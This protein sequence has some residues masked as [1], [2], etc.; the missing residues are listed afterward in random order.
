[1]P[2]TMSQAS[3]VVTRNSTSRE[4]PMISKRLRV[5]FACF[6]G[7]IFAFAVQE[8]AVAQGWSNGYGY[9]RA[10][11]IDHT[12]VAN[13]DQT[14][15][16]VLI[17]GTFSYLA[18]IENGGDLTSANGYDIIFTSDAAG[19]TPLSYERASYSSVTGA[20]IFWVKI[21]TL[22]HTSDTVIYMFYG[23]G[24]IS[25]DQS[26]KSGTWD[27]NYV[28]VWHFTNAG[29]TFGA[30]STSHAYNLT[31]N[32]SVTASTGQIGGGASFSGSN[33]L[34]NSSLSIT[35][36]TSITISFWNYVSSSNLTQDSTFTIGG[37]D[38]PNRI[39]AACPWSDSTLYWDYGSYSAGGRVSTSY[40]SYLNHWAHVVLEYDSAQSKHAIYINGV[41][42][43]SN[44]NSN[45]P[46]ATETGIDIGA[47]P[48]SY[49]HKGGLDEFRVSTNARSSDWIA[50]EFANQNA[51]S[52]FYAIGSADTTGSGG[53]SSPTISSLSP[54]SGPV[55]IPVSI[56]GTNFGASQG[57]N[58]VTFNGTTAYPTSWTASGI[59]V[60]VPSGATNGNVVVNVAGV[61]SNGANFTVTTGPGITEIYPRS[62]PIGTAVRIAGVN[63]GSTPGTVSLN[64]TTASTTTWADNTIIAIVPSGATSGPFVITVNGQTLYTLPFPISSL[65]PGW[66]DQD[67]GAAAITGNANFA[68]GV[69]TVSASGQGVYNSSDIL[70]FVYQPLS[71]DGSIVAR[72]VSSSAYT[73][74]AGVMIRE[75]FDPGSKE[76]VAQ[77]SPNQSYLFSRATA[78]TMP[79]YQTDG[80]LPSGNH[81]YWMKLTRTGNSF[82]AYDSMDGIHWTQIG[83]SVTIT[84]ATNVYIG[85]LF[86]NGN[87]SSL[88]TANFDNV[89]VSSTASPAPQIT[90]VSATTGAIGSQVV[91][92]G[93]GFGSYESGSLVYLNGARVAAN[94]WSDTAI[95][96][97]IPSGASSGPL[98]VS[99][100][101]G[102]NDT[103]PVQFTVTTQPLPAS[104]FDVEI[105]TGGA[106]GGVT[107]ANG[108]FSVGASNQSLGG[109]SDKTHFVYQ[110]LA[111]DG[112]IVARVANLA[113]S[114]PQ[115][116]V[117]IRESFDPGARYAFLFYSPYQAYM[118]FRSTTGASYN[119]QSAGLTSSP[120]Y[121]PYWVKLTRIGNSFT[122]YASLDGVN[123]LQIGSSQTI[124]MAQNVYIGLSAGDSSLNVAAGTFD[125]VSVSSGTTPAPTITGVSATTGSVGSQIV[126]N[127]SNFG[128]SQG[129][130]VVYLNGAS[131]P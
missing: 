113:G 45:V 40:S 52:S 117:M 83:S 97:T 69:F 67:I 82:A 33:Y 125:N 103:N 131:M 55:S 2:T 34:S 112:T 20:A 100:A 37:A 5:L 11:T 105:G 94:A 121:Y 78:G 77:Y 43:T 127:G 104:W 32:N 59:V 60:P 84:M 53:T 130:S 56:Y 128:S 49:Y 61:P 63:F 95:T 65:P 1:M 19:T 89:S 86:S 129:S 58:T 38:A 116:G 70:N 99:V 91:I 18:T 21:P 15:F 13:S 23:N 115:A 35:A 17:S 51:P 41:L 93:T 109:T 122:G 118:Y 10:I 39:Q 62:G 27:A 123:W 26:N 98:V 28:G 64:G 6:V 120:I 66:M 75:T 14:N 106:A 36:G 30:D 107:Y 71:G 46:Q 9:R 76:A 4:R 54:S 44:T 3:R 119:S 29:S 50:T 92:S 108:T 7:L 114:S 96:T 87:N 72:V 74:Q 42:A 90:G 110:P 88:G 85:L 102:M 22:S 24:A 79:A 68:N 111:G 48:T 80:S 25:V 81:L 8:R 16:S 73:P 101:P 57:Y 31:N 126:L 12:K 47:W 124:S